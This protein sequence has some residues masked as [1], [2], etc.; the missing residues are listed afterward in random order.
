MAPSAV[1]VELQRL[2][3]CVIGQGLV[4][5]EWLD[6]LFSSLP[7]A[8]RATLPVPDVPALRLEQSFARLAE[9]GPL[10]DGSLPLAEVADRLALEPII[11]VVDCA[12]RLRAEVL[13]KP[14]AGSQRLPTLAAA[15]AY[16]GPPAVKLSLAWGDRDDGA[17]R[18]E[19][20]GTRCAIVA[21]ARVSGKGADTPPT[22]AWRERPV[23]GRD[24]WS[25]ATVESIEDGE[26]G[27]TTWRAHASVQAATLRARR[28]DARVEIGD[29]RVHRHGL[30]V[31]RAAVRLAIALGAASVVFAAIW[32]MPLPTRAL[33]LALAGLV[34]PPLVALA[35]GLLRHRATR[36]P[37]LGLGTVE[38]S[39]LTAV[40]GAAL[41][42]LVPPR[43]LVIVQNETRA[44]VSIRTLDM[45]VVEFAPGEGRTLMVWDGDLRSIGGDMCLCPGIARPGCLCESESVRGIAVRTVMCKR[46]RWE[47]AD[48]LGAAVPGTALVGTERLRGAVWL[49]TG[50]DCRPLATSAASL[51]LADASD[52]VGPRTAPMIVRAPPIAPMF[53]LDAG[54][55][56]EPPG[57]DAGDGGA[58]AIGP[59]P[60]APPPLHSRP[61][62]RI[63]GRLTVHPP[64]SRDATVL[65]LTDVD[66][67][68]FAV[69]GP[70]S[71]SSE[72]AVGGGSPAGADATT[73]PVATA[74]TGATAGPDATPG[75]ESTAG[76]GPTDAAQP[77]AAP[78]PIVASATPWLTI[79]GLHVEGRYDLPAISPSWRSFTVDTDAGTLSCRLAAEAGAE[80]IELRAID[81]PP[82]ST[83][84]LE[85]PAFGATWVG[86][87]PGYTCWRDGATVERIVVS[88]PAL[89][90][91]TLLRLPPAGAV[92]VTSGDVT[93]GP[94]TCATAGDSSI[95]VIDVPRG[96]GAPLILTTDGRAWSIAPAD[97]GGR[98]LAL[99]CGPPGLPLRVTAGAA[100]Y[101]LSSSALRRAADRAR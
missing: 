96:L 99:L 87:L 101:E 40:T 93:L 43:L 20:G 60:P 23:F 35:H 63:R 5:H 17:W 14:P 77:S 3:A 83:V 86:G 11:A 64:W 75:V 95:A 9:T 65:R 25:P 53:D 70:A 45:A 39:A 47:G 62:G 72:A 2:Q 56:V 28:I 92:V 85:G 91:G 52:A 6:S 59:E 49:A 50:D 27:V 88:L 67:A 12:N 98:P 73:G 24:R 41:M 78:D 66:A 80:A 31:P 32:V 30:V 57:V 90:A 68:R 13:R 100:A 58:V 37:L 71:A 16:D 51:E 38:V 61:R 97:A 76:P 81:V 82:G 44:K 22:F 29:Q 55:G 21:T 1:D 46:Q 15:K 26:E 19:E 36:G 74:G 69:T 18:V 42:V 94:V 54:D 34:L 4:T 79:E 10:D 84:A 8:Y 48:V 89:T 33:L 7:P